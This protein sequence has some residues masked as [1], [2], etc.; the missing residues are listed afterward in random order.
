MILMMWEW[1]E[2]VERAKSPNTDSRRGA[3]EALFC[4]GNEV[5]RLAE[6]GSGSAL[7]IT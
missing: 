5:A 7:I 4:T 1:V 2:V 6:S 3:L